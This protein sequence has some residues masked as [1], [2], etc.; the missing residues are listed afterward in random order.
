[1][2]TGLSLTG[3]GG[4]FVSLPTVT[5]GTLTSDATYY[6][7]T[8]TAN[9]TLTVSGGAITADVLVVAGGG[10]AAIDTGGGGGAGGYRSFEPQLLP[11]SSYAVVIGAGGSAASAA[12]PPHRPSVPQTNG[13]ATSIGATSASGGGKG[14]GFEA[15]FGN[16]SPGGSGGGGMEQRDIAI[17]GAGNAGGYSPAEGHDGGDSISYLDYDPGDWVQ[18]MGGGGGGAGGIGASST[19]DEWVAISGGPGATWLNGVT[20]AAGG[21]GGPSTGANGAANSGNGGNAVAGYGAATSGAGGSGIV[22]VR[23]TRAQVDG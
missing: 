6:Y 8:F 23:Y 20:Y 15:G 21:A 17:G 7:R 18:A 5:G 10:G 13:N 14:A 3:A 11:P 16:G 1:M 4:S 2:P 22:V 19:N 12:D 9:G